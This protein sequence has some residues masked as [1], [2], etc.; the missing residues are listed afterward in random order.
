MCV[1]VCLVGGGGDVPAKR[2]AA[3][4]TTKPVRKA[5]AKRTTKRSPAKKPAPAKKATKTTKKAPAPAPQPPPTDSSSPAKG[6]NE[7]AVHA[8]LEALREERDFD[9]GDE[10][11][12]ALAVTLAQL[13]DGGEPV[14]MTLSWARE[15]RTILAALS[16]QEGPTGDTD[17]GAPADPP[18]DGWVAGLSTSLR[19]TA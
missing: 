17:P 5:P 6:T 12:A 4:K 15:L 10:V 19:H 1:C 3:K 7:T 9:T 8:H 13:L 18:A 2:P 16:H 14:T 11:N